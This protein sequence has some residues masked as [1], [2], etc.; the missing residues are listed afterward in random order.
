MDIQ[1]KWLTVV[2]DAVTAETVETEGAVVGPAGLVAGRMRR[3]SGCPAPSLVVSYS[4]YSHFLYLGIR[5]GK[6]LMIKV[7]S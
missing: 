7:I 5:W 1:T 4:R 3:R 6:N 2:V